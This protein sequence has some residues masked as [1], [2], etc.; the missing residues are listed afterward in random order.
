MVEPR[1]V[2]FA[3][4]DILRSSSEDVERGWTWWWL[5]F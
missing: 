5:C 3:T 2:A 4:N 1:V